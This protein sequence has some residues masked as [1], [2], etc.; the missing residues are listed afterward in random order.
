M[1]RTDAGPPGPPSAGVRKGVF[2]LMHRMDALVRSP[3]VDRRIADLAKRQHGVVTRRQLRALGA[4][5]GGIDT[6]VR[7]GRLH[8]IHR[9]VYAVGHDVLTRSGML[10][11]AVYACGE[12][13]VQSHR[14]AAELW[15]IGPRAAFFEVTAHRDVSV[16]RIRVHR[17]PVPDT[18]RTEVH[19]IPVT[20]PA[21]TIIDLADVLNRR[22]LER[23]IDEAEYLQLD[24]TGLVPIA[25]RRGSG[26]LAAVLAEHNAGSTR[27]RSELEEIGLALCREHHLTQPV[28]NVYVEGYEIDFYWPEQ[29]LVV[30][31]DGR[32]AHQ[33][34]TAFERDRARDAELT[35][36]G[37][38]VMRFT[39]RR[40]VT[41]A[42]GVA[43]QLRRAGAPAAPGRRSRSRAARRRRPRP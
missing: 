32:A 1:E 27:T 39:E 10:I 7:A 31:V 15:R 14:G 13:A 24:M 26:R 23:A 6:R 29:R 12:G 25:G 35:A 11:A 9:G 33:T 18:H 19:G 42:A 5:R 36:A 37:Y 8:R 38:R 21:R 41:D 2:G 40:A 30:E 34:R 28:T 16:P 20:T 22:G 43:D 4:G 17:A 3:R